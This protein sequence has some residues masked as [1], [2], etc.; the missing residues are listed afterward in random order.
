M[1]VLGE[2]TTLQNRQQENSNLLIFSFQ[3]LDTK[4]EKFILIFNYAASRFDKKMG[5]WRGKQR[6]DTHWK[7]AGSTFV[8]MIASY[9]TAAHRNSMTEN[10]EKKKQNKQYIHLPCGKLGR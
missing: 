9:V 5:V 6:V 10:L 1:F 4:D 8:R 7:N 3:S 2:S